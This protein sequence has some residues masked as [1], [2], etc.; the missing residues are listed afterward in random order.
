MLYYT[1]FTQPCEEKSTSPSEPFAPFLIHP[2]MSEEVLAVIAYLSAHISI[3]E[4]PLPLSSETPLT[5]HGIY[6]RDQIFAGLGQFTATV[7]PARGQREGVIF[8]REKN[9][10]VFFITLNKTEEHYSPTTMYEDYAINE[11]LFHWQSQ[12]TTSAESP[13]GQRYIH[14]TEQGTQVLLFVR[15]Y[16]KLKNRAEPYTCL[17]TA[18]Y[19]SHEGSRPMNIVWRLDVPM[20]PRLLEK[21]LKMSV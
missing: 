19:V 20:P 7:K 16:K 2:W 1:F 14:H 13:T 9:L 3:M 6:T 18:T 12:S 11:E 21:A 8:F 4:K 15:E 17:G 5:L 10:D